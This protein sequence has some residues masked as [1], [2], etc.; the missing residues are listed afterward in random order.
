MIDQDYVIRLLAQNVPTTQI[1]AAVGCDPSY[2]SQLKSDPTIQSH[3][4]A[5]KSEATLEDI[6]FDDMLARAEQLALE[7]I[8]KTLPFANMMQSL[9]ALKILNSARR[10]NEKIDMPQTVTNNLTVNL[11]LPTTAMPR[12]V[13]NSN[14]EIIEVEGQTML[15]ATPRSLDSLLNKKLGIP[16]S[17]TPV[18]ALN[19]AASRLGALTQ[20][21]PREPRK[22]PNPTS[23]DLGDIV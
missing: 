16:E 15:S 7:R 11:T 22:L 5:Q 18:T 2:I 23:I 21:L 20:T 19:R 1:A 17:A 8:E 6:K 13:T 14:N 4:E 10:R 12:F 9:A 3:V